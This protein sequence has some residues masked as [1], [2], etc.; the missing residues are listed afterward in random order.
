MTLPSTAATI[1]TIVP[2][3]HGDV[4]QL[5]VIMAVL[6]AVAR[7]LAEVANRI[8]QPPVVGEILAGVLLGPSLLSGLVPAAGEWLLPRTA[9]AGHLLELVGLLGAMFL[10]VI[11]GIETDLPLIRSHARTALGVAGGGLVLPFASGLVLAFLVPADLVGDPDRRVVFALFLA[12]ALSVSAIPVVAKVLMELGLIRRNFGQTVLAA[13]MVDDTVAWVLLS[14]VLALAGEG[15]AGPAETAL[16]AGKILAFLLLAATL[17]RRLVDGLLA[18]VQD[19]GRSPDRVLTLVVVAALGFGAAAQALG[20][21]AVLGA[22][23]AGVIFG[24]SPRLP[25]EVVRRLNSISLAVFSPVF[26]AIA[27]LKVRLTDLAEPRLLAIGALVLVVAVAGKVIGAYAAG[28]FMGLDRW[29]SFAYGSA[30]NARGAVGIIVASIGLSFG[31]LSTE[32]YSIVVVVAVVTS[33][34]TP[35]LVQWAVRHLPVDEAEQRRIDREEAQQTGDLGVIRRILIPVR[36]RSGPAPVHRLEAQLVEW[37][38][39]APAVTLLSVGEPESKPYAEWLLGELAPLFTTRHVTRRFVAGSPVPV[40]LDE[41]AKGHDLVILGAP[42]HGRDHEYLF[43]PIVDAVV[44]LAP[45]PSLIVTGRNLEGV[46]WPPRRILVPTSGSKASRWALELAL[47]LSHGRSIELFALHVITSSPYA[48]AGP[49]TAVRRRSSAHAD[50]V[51]AD[52]ERLGAAFRVPVRAIAATASEL[53]DTVVRTATE[54]GADLIVIGTAL[55]PGTER[56]FLGPRVETLL[57]RAPC[58]VLIVNRP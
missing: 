15:G 10:L 22:F 57:N 29:S 30:L 21:E 28:R 34:M 14:V 36:P 3:P 26:F 58:P 13:G 39:D 33:V 41:A 5:L 48:R 42:E 54:E 16:A 40:I 45:C 24:A 12:T 6:L 25:A 23:V 47:L 8:G 56:L 20:I 17:G 55:R 2:A 4:L 52:A 44:R 46:A 35:S 53:E 18:L 51:L 1:E 32:L 38:S 9:T 31:I 49:P 19:R 27:G 7:G 37:L 43:N 50:E 11:T